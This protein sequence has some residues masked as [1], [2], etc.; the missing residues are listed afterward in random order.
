LRLGRIAGVGQFSSYANC[1]IESGDSGGPLFDF[2]GR[3]I[4]ILNSSIGPQLRH[5]GQWVNISRILDGTTF[6]TD[7][8]NQEVVRLGFTN[9]KREAVDTRR[10]LANKLW[11]AVL[12]P[13]RRATV[14]VL[15]DGQLAILG[16]IV[17][18]NGHVLTKRSEIMTHRGILF[19]KLTCRLFDGELV[20]AKKAGDS[21]EDDA[22]LLELS[23]PGPTPAP[24]S[25]EAESRRG[26]IVV[27]PI[28]GKDLS[29]T[30]VVSLQRAFKIESRCGRLT[31]PVDSRE[32]GV[33]V[34]NAVRQR[35]CADLCKSMRGSINEGDVITHI[36]GEATPDLATYHK[37]AK[38]A[39][40]AGD[41]VQLSIRR[42][43]TASQVIFPIESD[44]PAYSITTPRYV[45]VSMR[46]TGFP[47]VVIHDA[48]V[49]R[50]EC[51]G[52]IVDLEGNVVGV[53]IARFHRCST[54]AI[55]VQRIRQVVQTL[56]DKPQR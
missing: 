37:I 3:L 1:L 56:L 51:G 20:A 47:A 41:F 11:S 54:F 10:H 8:D 5:P 28:P 35:D 12:A 38:G 52:P 50:R 4:G 16:T 22:A 9:A 33:T 17:D 43:R 32:A 18:T 36:E 55:P 19:G 31:L 13:A 46:L 23:K 49:T 25:Q 26:A 40:V 53:N 45:D 15:L 14:E 24:F 44:N 27:I 30:G 7:Y 48:M 39:F 29:E 6:L 42:K 2:D 34:T 21:P